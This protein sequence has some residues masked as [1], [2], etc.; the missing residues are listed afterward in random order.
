M[1]WTHRTVSPCPVQR[2][3]IFSACSA[4]ALRPPPRSQS[5]TTEHV[6]HMLQHDIVCFTLGGGGGGREH[7][8]V[9]RMRKLLQ[10][11]KRFLLVLH[12]S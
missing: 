5:A 7:R 10:N 3:I 9:G 4:A 1:C 11:K 2:A 6:A 12:M 8:K